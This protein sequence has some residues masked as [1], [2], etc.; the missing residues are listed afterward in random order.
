MGR[1]S[2]VM[3]VGP[4]GGKFRNLGDWAPRGYYSDCDR[5]VGV[6]LGLATAPMW[7]SEFNNYG[8]SLR[9]FGGWFRNWRR[10]SRLMGFSSNF[11][12][13]ARTLRTEIVNLADYLSGGFGPPPKANRN[14]DMAKSSTS[15]YVGIVAR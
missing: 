10:A 2:G 12:E 13:L 14:R 9:H 8:N 5:W 1:S 3:I 15:Q 7:Q 6:S 11:G 4:I